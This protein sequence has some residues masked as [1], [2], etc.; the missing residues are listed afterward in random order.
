M[1]WSVR[2]ES[3]AGILSE[4]A[5][6]MAYWI[7]VFGTKRT[8]PLASD[9]LN[10]CLRHGF[11]IESEVL[12]DDEE[13]EQVTFRVPGAREG[14]MVERVGGGPEGQEEV[15]EEV[16]PVIAT[17]EGRSGEKVDH[18]LETI[19]KT[20]QLFIIGVP[21]VTPARSPLRQLAQALATHLARETKGLYQIPDQGFYSADNELLVPDVL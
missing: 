6:S 19:R 8:C 4:K 17:F 9:L 1:G 20:K 2:A 5:R 14:V 12:G 21:L 13:W 7:R 18:V 11:E 16:Q 15:R 10:T 3:E